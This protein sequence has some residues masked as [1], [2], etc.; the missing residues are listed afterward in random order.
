MSQRY[1][2]WLKIH[3]IP[4]S[5]REGDLV[6]RLIQDT[7]NMHKLS[8]PWEGPFIVSKALINNAYYLIDAREHKKD[9]MDKEGDETE[10]PWNA[11]LLRRFYT[12]ETNMYVSSMLS[13]KE[14]ECWAHEQFFLAI[15]ICIFTFSTAAPAAGKLIPGG[16]VA[17]LISKRLTLRIRLRPAREQADRKSVV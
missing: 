1:Y 3:W 11:S 9:T 13:I 2:K 14:W 15:S 10:R 4:S 16:L 8:S 12:W 6:L 17:W 7:K 5:L